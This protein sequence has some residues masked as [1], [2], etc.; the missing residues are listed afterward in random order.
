MNKN[1]ILKAVLTKPCQHL[2]LDKSVDSQM[3]AR[4]SCNAYLNI[5]HI[6]TFPRFRSQHQF[7]SLNQKPCFSR[8]HYASFFLDDE[9]NWQLAQFQ[10][11]NHSALLL[12]PLRAA[13]ATCRS[14]G[15]GRQLT[16]LEAVSLFHLLLLIYTQLLLSSFPTIL[17]VY[18]CCL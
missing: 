15:Q 4:Q 1:N 3:H 8:Q 9:S 6:I 17:Y 11:N 18:W 13:T 7:S 2:T 12:G 10:I 14:L 5:V 16:R